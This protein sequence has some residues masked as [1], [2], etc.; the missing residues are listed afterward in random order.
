[1][2]IFRKNW[3]L[4]LIPEEGKKLGPMGQKF[5]KDFEEML[6]RELEPHKIYV[7]DI[8]CDNY[9]ITGFIKYNNN[10]IYIS[11]AIPRFG[12]LI[13]FNDTGAMRG[14]TYKITS[15]KSIKNGLAGR[16]CS[17]NTLIDT[18]ISTFNSL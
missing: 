5:V 1:M 4:A 14:V 8:S 12:D 17:L 18:I 9:V 11:Y 3:N 15:D 13:N 7:E 2:D 16:Y 10:Y 6:K